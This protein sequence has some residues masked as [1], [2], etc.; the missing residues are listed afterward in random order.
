MRKTMEQFYHELDMI[1]DEYPH[2]T[3]PTDYSEADYRRFSRICAR[4]NAQI[5]E[6]R[7]WAARFEAAVY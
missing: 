4:I 6:D 1:A 2:G 7:Y 3:E 5:E